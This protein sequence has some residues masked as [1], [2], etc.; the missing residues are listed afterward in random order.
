MSLTSFCWWCGQPRLAFRH[1]DP[2]D[3]TKHFTIEIH[4]GQQVTIHKNCEPYVKEYLRISRLTAQDQE[5]ASL[6]EQRKVAMGDQKFS[7]PRLGKKK[8]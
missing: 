8:G 2:A 4:D 7:D 6:T 5:Y 3:N 1:I